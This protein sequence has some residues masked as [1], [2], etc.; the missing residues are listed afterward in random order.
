[1]SWSSWEASAARE[2]QATVGRRRRA[3]AY[4]VG[5]LAGVA[6]RIAGARSPRP[7][8]ATE[9]LATELARI[10]SLPADEKLI[11]LPWRGP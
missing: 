8:S 7:L 3:P 9:Q 11:R 1:M 4:T 10:R 6:D 2:V 5:P